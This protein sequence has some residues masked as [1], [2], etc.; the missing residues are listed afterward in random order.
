MPDI[1]KLSVRWHRL[2]KFDKNLIIFWS[3][4]SLFITVFH[5]NISQPLLKITY[6]VV[7]IGLLLWILPWVDKKSG[8]VWRFF[9]YW[10]IVILLPFLYLDV[11]QFLHMVFRGEFDNY[12]LQLEKSLFGV[13]P[14]IWIQQIVNPYFTEIMQ[15]SYSIYW[16]TIPLGAAVFYFKKQYGH[17]EQLLHYVTLTF[18]ISYFFFIFFPVAGPRFFLANQI[19]VPYS[20]IFISQ[21][22]RSF[23]TDVGYR[24]GAFPSSHVGVAVVILIFVWHFHPRIAKTVFLPMVLALSLATVYGQYHYVTDV[25]AGLTMGLVI[26]FVGG[27]HSRTILGAA[28]KKQKRFTAKSLSSSGNRSVS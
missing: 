6:H 13:H 11:G 15:L 20:G 8:P 18:F 25:F 17:L 2:K 22:L 27:R 12:I 9:R 14:N 23:V 7:L 4:L 26:G 5:N 10:Y 1:L 3:I 24:G 19:T 28:V 21:Y 16:T